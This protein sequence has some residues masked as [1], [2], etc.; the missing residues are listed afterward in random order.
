MILIRP[1]RARVKS[2]SNC[3]KPR[4]WRQTICRLTGGLTYG[5]G[6][7]SWPVLRARIWRCAGQS[8][9]AVGFNFTH[10]KTGQRRGQVCFTASLRRNIRAQY[11]NNESTT[12]LHSSSSDTNAQRPFS[13]ISL[14]FV[15]GND[16]YRIY[17]VLLLSIC[18]HNVFFFLNQDDL[19][20]YGL[21][22]II[23]NY[24]RKLYLRLGQ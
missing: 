14:T 22:G 18:A 2:S 8:L 10:H 11:V 9:R 20:E 6:L 17:H 1:F 19:V 7:G 21:G 15:Q 4:G 5:L 24:W 3:Q 23:M 13:I 16:M 12:G